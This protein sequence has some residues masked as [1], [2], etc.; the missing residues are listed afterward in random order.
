MAK[1]KTSTRL[2]SVVAALMQSSFEPA[3]KRRKRSK[4][5]D[6]PD[7]DILW[8]NINLVM[9]RYNLSESE[10]RECLLAAIGPPQNEEAWLR[11]GLPRDGPKPTDGPKSD[12][13]LDA[14][15]LIGL[16]P[17]DPEEETLEDGD[18][19]DLGEEEEEESCAPDEKV[20]PPA[21]TIPD[22]SQEHC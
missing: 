19:E 14:D 7:F 8:T 3:S 16:F 1:T 2:D 17:E 9:E 18:G 5:A 11:S 21:A 13:E 4:T 12:D 10:A 6:A 15:T 20:D 22:D